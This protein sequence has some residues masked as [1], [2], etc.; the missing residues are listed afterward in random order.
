MG[1]LREYFEHDHSRVMGSHIPWAIRSHDGEL[2]FE[3][4]ARVSLDLESNAK[5][6]SFYFDQCNDVL[7]VLNSMFDNPEVQNCYLTPEGDPVSVEMGHSN[8]DEM[9]SSST[10][11][12]TRRIFLYINEVLE[13]QTRLAIKNLGSERGFFVV[14]RDR[15]YAMARSDSEVP[16]AFISH[17]SKDKD[18][19]VRE[20]ARELSSIGCSVWYDEYSLQ[21]GDSLREK[22]E[23]G[24]K[25][26]Q[27][28]IIVLSTN[29]L[30]NEGWGKAE[31]DSIFTREILE[32]QNVIL[33]VWHGVTVSDVYNYSPRMADKVGLNSTLGIKVLAQKLAHAIRQ[34]G[35]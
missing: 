3:L 9:T 29:F 35:A 16:L 26:A 4:V 13:P 18:P 21:V 15:T 11:I 32:K 20:L 14:T 30:E 31:F 2:E 23:S 6:W 33:P 12:F 19:L 28:C 34:P 25:N 22:I 5:F 17:D 7:N 24:L 27:K 10:L 1:T 8:Y